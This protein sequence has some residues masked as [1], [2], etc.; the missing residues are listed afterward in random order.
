MLV[1]GADRQTLTLS[2]C[3][4]RHCS[5]DVDYPR[6]LE[7]GWLFGSFVRSFA[8]SL[9]ARS[10]VRSF[11]R[12]LVRSFARSF[13]SFVRF[14]LRSFLRSLVLSFVWLVPSFLRSFLCSFSCTV[15]GCTLRCYQD[16]LELEEA[17]HTRLN[18]VV[19]SW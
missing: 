16:K 9:A 1:C 7:C 8:G 5:P 12:S 18:S 3:W 2:F 14:R 15:L 11:V 4:N 19:S 10:F 17:T 6:S 13:G